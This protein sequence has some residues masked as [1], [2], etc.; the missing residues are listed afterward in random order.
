LGSP[1][2]TAVPRPARGRYQQ[3]QL[4]MF[5]VLERFKVAMKSPV[6]KQPTQ[7]VQP[8]ST[9]ALLGQLKV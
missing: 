3:V 5:A 8:L 6:P 4:E 7:R 1:P 9:H 2:P